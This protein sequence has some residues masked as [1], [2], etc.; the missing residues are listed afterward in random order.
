MNADKVIPF[1][2]KKHYLINWKLNQVHLLNEELWS[3]TSKN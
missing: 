2:K 1:Q 3:I